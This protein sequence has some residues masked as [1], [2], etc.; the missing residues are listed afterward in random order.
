MNRSLKYR[1]TG[2]LEVLEVQQI[3]QKSQNIDSQR[4]DSEHTQIRLRIAGF[5]QTLEGASERTV[6]KVSPP[7]ALQGESEQL[8]S[9]R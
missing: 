7:P 8:I 6:G 2:C 1:R 4:A 3:P 5:E 9:T